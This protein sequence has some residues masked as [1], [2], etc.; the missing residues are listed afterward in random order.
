MGE[1][2]RRYKRGLMCVRASERVVRDRFER[3]REEGGV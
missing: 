3:E 2:F 1:I